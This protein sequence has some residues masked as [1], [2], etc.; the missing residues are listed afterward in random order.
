MQAEDNKYKLVIFDCDGVILNSNKIKTDAFYYSAEEYGI[1]AAEALVNYHV[2]N[3]GVS[4][5]VKFEYFKTTILPRLS[6]NLEVDTQKLLNKYGNYV[7][8][9]LLSCE[10]E[11][12]IFELKVATQ[13]A[14]WA[15]ASGSDQEELR[16]IMKAR[17]LDNLFEA[18]IW[19]SPKTKELIFK[20]NFNYIKPDEVL[21]VGDSQYDHEAA[22]L[23]GYDFKFI[24]QWSEFK[25][26]KSYADQH[27]IEVMKDLKELQQKLSKNPKRGQ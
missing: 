11:P 1:S 27:N 13:D 16:G 18:G 3:G 19:G 22:V 12:N 5:Y 20:E 21:F 7:A 17:E 23:F 15:V 25:K 9:K 6:I 8:E 2:G 24:S 4:R 10:L 14:Q 26:L